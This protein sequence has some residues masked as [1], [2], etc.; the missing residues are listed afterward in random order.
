[1]KNIMVIWADSGRDSY[2]GVISTYLLIS[3][4][5]EFHAKV[6]SIGE[7][8]MKD[9]L[10]DKEIPFVSLDIPSRILYKFRSVSL[11]KKVKNS[12]LILKGVFEIIKYIIKWDSQIILC[13]DGV[14]F[15]FSFIPAKIL[16][17]SLIFIVRDTPSH[18]FTWEL[19]YRFSNQIIVL[20]DEMR[21]QITDGLP[22]DM[23]DSIN[24]KIVKINNAIPLDKIEKFKSENN[25]SDTRKANG[26]AQGEIA[27]G[28]V[29]AFEA[30]KAQLEFISHLTHLKKSMPSDLKIKIYFIGGAKTDEDQSYM[31]TC[32]TTANELKLEEL[33]SFVGY[34]KEMYSWYHS[35]DIIVLA[36]KREGQPRTFIESLAFGKPVVCTEVLSAHELLTDP[37]AG[38]VVPQGAYQSF[39]NALLMLAKDVSLREKMGK[40][41]YQYAKDNLDIKKTAKEFERSLHKWI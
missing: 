33:V 32:K 7:T 5:R 38:I 11:S 35:L 30:R 9:K 22:L 40:N 24:H 12:L 1:M 2:G 31:N 41:A 26:I 28:Y 37:K 14:A 17:K 20:S 39:N 18:S 16:N 36:S 34:Q 19:V 8:S 15:L 3:N 4:F 25:C 13:N 10:A 6:L 21:K 27:V 23:Q 29:G